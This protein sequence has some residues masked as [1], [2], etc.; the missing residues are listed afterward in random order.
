MSGV[1]LPPRPPKNMT[2]SYSVI[3]F[4]RFL[5]YLVFF[6]GVITFVAVFGPLVKAE[7]SYRWDSTRGVKRTVPNI[8]VSEPDPAQPQASAK[9]SFSD[10]DLGGEIIRPVDVNFGIVIEK[11]N[12]NAKV[13]PNVDPG[14]EKEYIKALQSGVAH[15]KGTNFPGEKGNIYLFSHSTD[16]PWNVARF[17][18]IFYLLKELQ[19]GDRVIMFYNGRRYDY[20]V[21]DK[22]I[23]PP[24]DV[25]FLTNRYAESVLTLQTCDPPG[26][27]LN[28]LIIR[29]KLASS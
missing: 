24:S 8:V 12:A 25:S 5:G 7:A 27:S 10:L 13:V 26:T 23:I 6:T 4:V 9:V 16:A 29:A 22:Q 2:K 1:R 28:R 20:I 3:L 17:N 21:F 19:N 11:I 15:A 18:A 14:N